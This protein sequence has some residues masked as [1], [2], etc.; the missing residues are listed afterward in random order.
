MA[1]DIYI[2]QLVVEAFG[3]VN[4]DIQVPQVVV[5]VFGN[6]AAQYSYV[7]S[8]S[9]TFAGSI[10]TAPAINKTMSAGVKVEP[11]FAYTAITPITR[12]MVAGVKVGP[13]FA[14]AYYPP[15]TRTMAVG[16]KVT[17]KTKTLQKTI[18]ISAQNEIVRNYVLTVLIDVPDDAV[19]KKS[20]GTTLPSKLLSGKAII[21]LD[22]LT[23]AQTIGVYYA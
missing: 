21:K 20:D 10:P 23:T 7:A 9:V 8:G 2:P 1:A 14:M 22:L 16:V 3:Q 19:F 4:P 12:T 15:I 13:S 17:G 18:K 6:T 11:S 5:E